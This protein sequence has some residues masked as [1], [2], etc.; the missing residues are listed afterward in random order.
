MNANRIVVLEKGMI[1]QVGTHSSLIE[2]D[3]PYK[4][5]YE[6]QFQEGSQKKIIQIRNT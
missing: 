6:L 3:G 5:L 2:T 4:K 1:A